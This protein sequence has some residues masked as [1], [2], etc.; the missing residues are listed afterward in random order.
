MAPPTSAAGGHV[1]ATLPGFQW[2]DSLAV[3]EDGRV[4]V[5]TLW[6]GGVTVFEPSGSYEHIA[7]PDPVTTNICFGG[8][9]M[10]DAWVTCS[11]SGRLYRCRWPRTG[12]RLSFN[13]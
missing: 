9:D 11:S 12:L 1:V 7:F 4:C 2:L 6:N 10:R 8:A 5:A 3:E 13:A